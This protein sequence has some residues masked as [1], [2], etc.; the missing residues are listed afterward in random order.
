[1]LQPVVGRFENISSLKGKRKRQAEV[2]LKLDRALEDDPA[3]VPESV[4]ART[5][6]HGSRLLVTIILQR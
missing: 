6:G 3:C 1:M 5:S 4:E 2:P